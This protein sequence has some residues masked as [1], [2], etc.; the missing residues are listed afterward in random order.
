MELNQGAGKAFEAALAAEQT[1]L[2]RKTLW[3]RLVVGGHTLSYVRLRPLSSLQAIL[4][5]RA[6]Q[7]LPDKV[8]GLISKISVEILNLRPSMLVSLTPEAPH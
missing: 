4:D 3:Y 7:A 6:D 5:E 8:S 2:E 1:K